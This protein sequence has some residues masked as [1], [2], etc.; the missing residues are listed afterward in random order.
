MGNCFS[1]GFAKGHQVLKNYLG[2]AF[3]LISIY[4]FETD[5][6]KNNINYCHT[7]QFKPKIYT[8]NLFDVKTSD[9]RIK[10]GNGQSIQIDNFT[11]ED[12]KI[13]PVSVIDV[14]QF[15][16]P[17]WVSLFPLPDPP[18]IALPIDQAAAADC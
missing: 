3:E 7:V 13:V 2:Y 18:V 9:A 17:V 11:Y 1:G 10:W 15:R 5:M 8:K 6:S 12:G 14:D 16:P 4:N